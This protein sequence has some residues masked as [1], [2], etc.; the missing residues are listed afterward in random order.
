[1][2][3]CVN[4][5]RNHFKQPS[6]RLLGTVIFLHFKQPFFGDLGTLLFIFDRIQQQMY[7]VQPIW[8]IPEPRYK[9]LTYLNSIVIQDFFSLFLC[10]GSEVWEGSGM[11]PIGLSELPS[12]EITLRWY[13]SQHT[14]RQTMGVS[15]LDCLDKQVDK[16]L[17][18]RKQLIGILQRTT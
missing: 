5:E 3:K 11:R 12:C 15:D 6:V 7:I 4:L 16:F 14:T 13:I 9:I 1:M 18:P 17:L 8:N 2:S 10:S